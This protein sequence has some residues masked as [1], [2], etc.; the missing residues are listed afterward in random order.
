VNEQEWAYLAGFVDA[1]GAITVTRGFS[2]RS[3]T[4]PTYTVRL[5]VSNCDKD[6]IDWLVAE[7]GGGVSL[8]NRNAP[9][10]HRSLWRW[11]VSGTSAGP[12]LFSLLPYLHIKQKRA[13]LA[14]QFIGTIGSPG[15]PGLT[16]E[17][18]RQRDHIFKHLARM[19]QR[20]RAR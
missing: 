19:N 20:G 1:D 15:G 5:G 2:S 8:S 6:I 13:E 12:I 18:V 7:L 16:K 9:R 17:V 11:S 4:R 14:L 10:H 3:P